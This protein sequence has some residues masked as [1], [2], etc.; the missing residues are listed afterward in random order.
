MEYFLAASVIGAGYVFNGNGKNRTNQPK[1]IANV[2]ENEIYQQWL[3]ST[4]IKR[5]VDADEV[6][7]LVT[8]LSSPLSGSITGESIACGGG[9]GTSIYP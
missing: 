2:P 9:V 7:T 1:Y 8:F 4:D 5:I 3:N 6:A